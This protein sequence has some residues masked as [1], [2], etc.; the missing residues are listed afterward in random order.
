M[1]LS[2]F[3]S[4][5]GIGSA[6]LDQALKAGNDVTVLVRDPQ[7]LLYADPHLHVVEGDAKDPSSVQE[8]IPPGTNA[9]FNALGVRPGEGDVIAQATTHMIEAMRSAGVRRYIGVSASAIYIDR[10]DP[11]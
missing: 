7:K 4:T 9:V 11:L 8:A 2:I 5:G 6:L 1:K 3:G 10:Y